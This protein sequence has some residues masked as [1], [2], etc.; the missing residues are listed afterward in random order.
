MKFSWDFLLSQ[1]CE[2]SQKESTPLTIQQQ[3]SW[4]QVKPEVQRLYQNK[5]AAKTGSSIG[6]ILVQPQAAHSGQSPGYQYWLCCFYWPG[7][8]KERILCLFS[9]HSLRD[10][11]P[12]VIGKKSIYFLGEGG[13]IEKILQKKLFLYKDF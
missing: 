3:L 11:G 10:L 4:W 1:R 7:L 13:N 5:W 2:I 8:S 12:Q 6:T 9:L